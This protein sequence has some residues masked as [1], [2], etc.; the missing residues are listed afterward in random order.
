M[1]N[2]ILLLM[3]FALVVFVTNSQAQFVINDF[4][5]AAADSMFTLFGTGLDPDAGGQGYLNMSDDTSDPFEGDA[6]LTCEWQVHTT[7]SWGGFLQLQY[8]LPDSVDAW[9][10]S[11]AEYISIHYKNISPS[12]KADSVNMRLKLHDGGDGRGTAVEDWYFDSYVV[13]DNTETGWQ[14]LLI[15]LKV[16]ENPVS[17]PPSDQGFTLPGWSGNFNGN[18]KL[19][20]D[21]IVGYSIEWPAVGVIVSDSVASGTI[22]W[23]MMQLKGHK[24]PVLHLFETAS[25][26][27]NIAFNGTGAS[28]IV[29]TD[30]SALGFEDNAAQLD[31][32]VDATESWG[33]YAS[34]TVNSDTLFADML[35]HTHISLMYNNLVASSIPG[36]VTLRVELHDYSNSDTDPEVWYYA[37]NNV[38]ES[39]PGWQQL[40]LPL[41]DLGMGT[42]PSDAGFSNPGWAGPQGNSKLDFD[43]IG[44]FI[45]EFS[46]SAQG[47]N[48]TG[49]LLLDNMELYGTRPTDLT[50]PAAVQGLA[51]VPG[52]YI[53]VVTWQ[54]VPDEE[55]ETYDVYYSE[56]PITD[57]TEAEVV[58]LKIAEDTRVVEHRLLAPVEDA[59]VT[60]YYAIRATDKVGNVSEVSAMNSAVTNTARG[61]VTISKVAPSGF[62]ADGDLGEWSGITPFRMFPS[63]G[64]PIV[65]NTSVDNDADLSVLAYLAVDAEYLYIAF[66]VTDDVTSPAVAAESWLNDSPDLFIGLYD[67]HGAPHQGFERGTHPDYQM[68]FN[69]SQILFANPGNTAFM[70]SDSADF[71]WQE[72]FVN[73]YIVEARISWESM[74]AFG[75]DEVFTPVEG[76]RI[77]LDFSV[78]DADG[79]PREGIM[80]YSVNNQDR[81][82][83][84][85]SRWTYTWIG[86]RSTPVSVE[87]EIEVPFTYNLS[88]NYPNPF[89]PSTT[90][91]YSIRKAGPVEVVVYNVLGQRVRTLVDENKPAGEHHIQFDASGLS[92]GVY[93]Y[94]IQAGDF[95]DTKK[96]LLMK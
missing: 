91:A 70:T 72:K 68:R 66:D 64:T 12:S 31:W 21:N 50:P 67:W 59:E 3:V 32:T 54:D 9:D 46:A 33:G 29:I 86:E 49:T 62:A 73:G 27:T 40:L 95:V 36:N 28:S 7:E 88:Q 51:A 1:R 13:Y 87:D 96:L 22:S 71:A 65:T 53:N 18:Q 5:S 82:W 56:T 57:I 77:P 42:F 24:N 44:G 75:G 52:E 79:A 45:I 23:D 74:A 78:N 37:N 85:P 16:L 25:S 94:R 84:S 61:V 92:S 47:T 14:E 63:E 58:A 20:F 93:F 8:L 90:I 34:M 17:Q 76:M 2:V 43:K 55:G 83:Q 26:D 80:T 15:P 6:S 41:E 38:L 81:S 35:G 89:N 69:Q 11:T 10:F 48:T 39:G 19:D 60:Y 4:E 30:N